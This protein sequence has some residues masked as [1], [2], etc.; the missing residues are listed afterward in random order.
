MKMKEIRRMLRTPKKDASDSKDKT[1]SR[2]QPARN[3]RRGGA[4]GDDDSV[5]SHGNIQNLI[6]YSDEEEEITS[7]EDESF[8][9][10]ATDS[11]GE[12]TPAERRT[13]RKKARRAALKARERIKKVSKK[14]AM[15]KKRIV[16]S[17]D[18][19]ED[20]EEEEEEEEEEE[21]Y[22]K[23]RSHKKRKDK[24]ESEEEEEDEEE[25]EEDD[26][27]EEE[28]E[29]EM[30]GEGPPEISIN[31]G[32]FGGDDFMERMIPKRH[33]MKKQT[34]DVKKFVKLI[35]KPLQATTIDDQI[36]SFKALTGEKQKQMIE[37]LERKPAQTEQNLMFRIL[38]MNIPPETQTMIL[39]KYHSL[40]TLDSSSG[41]FFKMRNWLDKVTSLPLGIYKEIPVKMD[42]GTEACSS[43]MERARR[44]LEEAIYGQE[45]AKLQIMQFIAT[46]IANPGHRGLS[47]LLTGP[48]GIGK[49]SLIRN[50]IAKALGWPFQFISLGGDS[51][52]TT[53]T[54]HQLVYE[55][56]H[57]GKIAHSLIHAKSMSMVLMF[58]ELDKIS[59]T[60]KGEEV[61][62]MLIHLTDP[63]Q[64]EDFEDKYLA[65][66][67]LDL[68]KVMF[69]FSGNDLNKIDRVL[70]DR[71]MHIQL[72]GYQQKDKLAIAENFL[73]PSALRDVGLTEKVAIS[74]EVLEHML[75]EYANEETGVRELKRCVEQIAQKINMLRI[76]NAKELPFYI[77]DFHLPF[78]VKKEHI[79]LFLKKKNPSMDV[80]VQRMYL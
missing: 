67:P 49:T 45:E 69:V 15:K 58:D 25:E 34:P 75:K 17:E 24:E 44:C 4:K 22:R 1:S 33:N 37:A 72:Q 79:D 71:M 32:G 61:Q 21:R 53:Y 23:R 9:S 20:D 57:A 8:D 42:D 10:S 6:A 12:L 68:S 19:E 62:N 7:S 30:E 27:E 5:D 50:G 43:F 16:E 60:P 14:Y 74:K 29:E 35:S 51:D 36:D 70:M 52:A 66:V 80:S 54:G 41:E 2:K 18:E 3:R 26:D 11:E 40:Q 28:Y 63:V 46:K 77:K 76:F 47:L 38:S 65:G 59:A 48:P 56:S 55:S 78:V 73:I 31:I 13:N 64:N 39:A